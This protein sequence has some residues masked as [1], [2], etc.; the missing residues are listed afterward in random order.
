LK[1]DP[2]TRAYMLLHAVE[3]L[4]EHVGHAQLTRQVLMA[5]GS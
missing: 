4:R 1:G 2:A 3:H 5:S